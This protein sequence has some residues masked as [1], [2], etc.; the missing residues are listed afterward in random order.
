MGNEVRCAD[1]ICMVFLA[2]MTDCFEIESK[3]IAHRP[4]SYLRLA[5]QIPE[6]RRDHPDIFAL[7]PVVSTVTRQFLVRSFLDTTYLVDSPRCQALQCNPS[8]KIP[9][10]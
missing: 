3:Y 6:A 5:W 1:E 10:R 7:S 4:G 9:A 2:L 8:E